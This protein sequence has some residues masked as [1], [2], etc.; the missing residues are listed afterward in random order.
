MADL[1]IVALRGSYA[2]ALCCTEAAGRQP[3]RSR[4]HQTRHA[5]FV[6]IERIMEET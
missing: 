4:L 3:A 2:L 1:E 5:A 6:S